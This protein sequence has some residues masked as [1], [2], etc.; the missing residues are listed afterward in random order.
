MLIAR[1]GLGGTGAALADGF[2]PKLF[3]VCEPS[4]PPEALTSLGRAPG[5][6]QPCAHS[7]PIPVAVC[8]DRDHGAHLLPSLRRGHGCSGRSFAETTTLTLRGSRGP[9]SPITTWLWAS[10]LT[11]GK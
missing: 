3:E 9:L 10:H 7:A 2:G 5:M 11:S 1:L 6:P 4:W 8:P